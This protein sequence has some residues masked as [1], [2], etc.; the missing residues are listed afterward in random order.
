MTLLSPSGI[1]VV[2]AIVLL[3]AFG[4]AVAQNRSPG[5][6]AI[7]FSP[8]EVRVYWNP[9]PAATE[10]RVLRDDHEI[11]RA[12]IALREFTDS[13]AQPNHN[14]RYTVLYGREGASQPL[15]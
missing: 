12:A 7:A 8:T 4:P 6:E 13:Q 9:D 11:G 14:Y 1:T 2:A 10:Y 3:L 5:V 15:A